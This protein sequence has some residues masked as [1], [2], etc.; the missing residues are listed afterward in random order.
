M[1][2]R[3]IAFVILVALAILAACESTRCLEGEVDYP[4]NWCMS[5]SRDCC[6]D[7]PPAAPDT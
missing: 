4:D 2:N 1:K 6:A 3:L 7:P 5:V